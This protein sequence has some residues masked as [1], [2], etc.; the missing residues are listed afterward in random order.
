MKQLIQRIFPSTCR[1]PNSGQILPL[2]TRSQSMPMRSH[3][4]T[5]VRLPTGTVARQTQSRSEE[6]T[7]IG[8]RP[9][10]IVGCPRSGTTLLYHMILSS[11]DFA[12][13]PL[14]SNTFCLFGL[15]F[16][17]L[18]SVRERRDLLDFW[19][20]SQWFAVSALKRSNIESKVLEEC[21]NIGD[22]L[23]IVMEEMCRRQGV[24][25]WAEKSPAHALYIPDIKR[26]IPDSLFVHI[27][28]DGRD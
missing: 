9:V 26:V 20:A 21:R 27:I 1:R 12:V 8:T 24:R 16:P 15:K 25:R 5:I 18:G 22:F 4:E 6:Q 28:R 11:G 14:E 13:F 23:Q 10:F 3:M 17:N 7:H 19:L 2:N